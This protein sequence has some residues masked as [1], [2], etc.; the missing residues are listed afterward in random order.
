LPQA[1]EKVDYDIYPMKF[2]YRYI[3]KGTMGKKSFEKEVVQNFY[4]GVDRTYEIKLRSE[5]K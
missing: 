2:T 3:L 5:E 4:V 1:L